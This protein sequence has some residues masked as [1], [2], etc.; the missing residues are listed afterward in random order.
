MK[1]RDINTSLQHSKHGSNKQTCQITAITETQWSEIVL[2]I[3]T[4]D[5]IEKKNVTAWPSFLSDSDVLAR[6]PSFGKVGAVP[7]NL[8]REQA[9]R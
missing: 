6:R 1:Y 3:G 8:L 4:F 7:E 2:R 5:E 9:S